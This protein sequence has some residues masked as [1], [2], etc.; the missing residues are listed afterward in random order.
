VEKGLVDRLGGFPVAVALAK[1][2]AGL[3]ASAA[4]KVELFDRK[5][6]FLEQLL[7]SDDDEEGPELADVLLR[8]V[9]RSGALG[10][11]LQRT[12]GL[13]GLARAVL[14]GRQTVYPVAEFLVDYR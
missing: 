12:P 9:L 14:G 2:K 1:E 11:S 5:T 3:P 6:N 13:L 8:E 4:V 10:G 7:R